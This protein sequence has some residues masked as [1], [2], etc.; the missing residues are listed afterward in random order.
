MDLMDLTSNPQILKSLITKASFLVDTKREAGSI[1]HMMCQEDPNDHIYLKEIS[2]SKEMNSY[3]I[4]RKCDEGS[5][6]VARL[7]DY[8]DRLEIMYHS[9]RVIPI[10][11]K[12]EEFLT[13]F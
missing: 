4:F 6:M 7:N 10:Y 11:V 2:K 1:M 9:G 8:P 5:L 12:T 3:E 13:L